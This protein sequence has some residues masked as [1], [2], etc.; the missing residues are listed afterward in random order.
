MHPTALAQRNQQAEARILRAALAI[1]G[2]DLSP[3]VERL[4]SA[5]HND[6]FIGQM[7]K[8]EALADLLEALADSIDAQDDPFLPEQ[9]PKVI[10][11]KRGRRRKEAEPVEA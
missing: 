8:R 4:K 11:R 10:L 7:L 6:I 3:L 1:A 5:R 2:D 9:E